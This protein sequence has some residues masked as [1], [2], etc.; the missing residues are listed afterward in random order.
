MSIEREVEYS[1][2]SGRVITWKPCGHEDITLRIAPTVYP[3]REDST[4]LDQV[5]AEHGSG[6]GKGML[7]IGCGSG[8]ISISCS[9]RGWRVK[10]CDINPLAVATTKGNANELGCEISVF[11]GGPGDI[12]QWMP[13]ESVDLIAWNLP[14]LD[15]EPGQKLGPLE[16]SA[17]IDQQGDIALLDALTQNPH[18][19]NPGGVIYLVHSSNH[20]GTRIPTTWRRAGWATRNIS[21]L[22]VG[23]EMLTAIACWRPFEQGEIVRLDSCES[24]NEIILE[25]NTVN[26]GDLVSTRNQTAGR[27]YRNRMWVGS[28]RNFMGSWALHRKS[29]EWGPEFIQY[30]ASLAVIDTLSTFMNQ[31]LPTHSW[32]HTSKLEKQGVRVKWPNDIWIR[33][34]GNV[35]KLCGIL[36]QGRSKGQENRIALG[37]GLNRNSVPEIS[38]S[39]GWDVLFGVD[40]EKLIPVLHASVASILEFHPFIKPPKKEDILSAVFANM[41]LT[42]SEGS[43]RSFGIDAAGGLLGINQVHQMSEDWGWKWD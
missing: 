12:D 36:A 8:A 15:P 20:V 18:I 43:P 5:L 19:L 9:L 10:A 39:I 26:Q 32:T 42:L 11:E 24:T 25:K 7:E 34:S 38:D 2:G 27:G 40:V 33:R 3:P 13:S 4:L 41:R 23:D 1:K 28:E 37:I 35:G 14:Y 30:A 29:I 17:M 6:E 31:G 22:A 21:K 16:D